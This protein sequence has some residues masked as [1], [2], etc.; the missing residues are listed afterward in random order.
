MM[1]DTYNVKLIPHYCFVS[2][3]AVSYEWMILGL[4]EDKRLV[5]F[6]LIC[7]FRLSSLSPAII[8]RLFLCSGFHFKQET[9]L[10]DITLHYITLLCNI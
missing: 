9:G 1:R 2:A 3:I 7:A 5:K 6:I 8:T 4:Y 10:T